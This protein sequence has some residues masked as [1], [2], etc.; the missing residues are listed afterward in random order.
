[1]RV[2]LYML[3]IKLNHV[4]KWSHWTI[5]FTFYRRY[6]DLRLPQWPFGTFIEISLQFVPIDERPA[7]VEGKAWYWKST[8]HHLSQGWTFLQHVKASLGYTEL[9]ICQWHHKT[10]LVNYSW[11][12][13][14]WKYISNS[15]ATFSCTAKN[16]ANWTPIFTSSEWQISS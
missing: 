4:S 8:S 2:Y 3:G 1:M 13:T 6:F 15:C 11:G 5:L 12:L 14:E 7:L 9:N 10:L 16:R